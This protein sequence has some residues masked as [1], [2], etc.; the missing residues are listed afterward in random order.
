MMTVERVNVKIH[1]NCFLVCI[2]QTSKRSPTRFAINRL[3]NNDHS[4]WCT[5]HTTYALLSSIVYCSVVRFVRTQS[6]HKYKEELHTFGVLFSG[7]I[8]L[9][10]VSRLQT[11]P[12]IPHTIMLKSMKSRL[13]GI[14]VPCALNIACIDMKEDRDEQ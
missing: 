2:I 11:L 10:S 12:Y 7:F 9:F 6:S 4:T 8:R 14:T 1:R 5:V 13:I 3:D